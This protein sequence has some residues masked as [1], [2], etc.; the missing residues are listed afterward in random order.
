ME[1][2]S[3][4]PQFGFSFPQGD[5]LTDFVHSNCQMGGGVHLRRANAQNSPD[6]ASLAN[7]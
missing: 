6:S 2:A 4:A 7:G 3:V 5:G 1:N